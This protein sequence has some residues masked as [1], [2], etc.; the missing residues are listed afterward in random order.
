MASA[1]HVYRNGTIL[2]MDSGG[3]Q[4]QAL[5]VRGETILAVGSDAEIMALADPHTVVTD[6][7]GRTM[8]PGFID[9]HSHFV[10]AG[11]MAATQLD[12][13]SPPVGGVKNIAEIK[14]LIRAKAAE[15]PKGEW[16]L[17]FGYDDTGLED[18]R[19]PLASDIDEV[20]PEHPVLLRHVSGHLSACN[21][22]ALAKA[23][24]TKDTP[25]PVGG[26]IRRD[27][28]G[29]PNGVLEEPPAREPV[30][31]HIPA[32]T[33]ADW[34][35]GI[36]A[37]CAAYTAKGVTTAQ[38]GFTATGDWGAL[39][40]AHELGL[41]R[42]RVQILPGLGCCDLNQFT[43]H[44]SGT[45][46]TA[47]RKISL[48]AVKHLVDGSLQCY[49]GCLSNPYHK[50]IYDLPDGPMWRGY[51]QENPEGFI[52]RIVALH[53]QGW[54]IAIH[55]NGD[56]AIQ[57]ILDAYE[58]AQKRY[59]RAD[60]RH[61]IIHCQTVREDQ[62][63]RIKRL[64][65]VPSFFVVHT[66]FW[67]DRHRDIFLGPDR[68]KRISPLRSA[69]KRGILFSNH[70]DTFVTPI[71]PLLSVWSAVNRITSSGQ[72]LGEEYTIS[73]MDALRSV[74]SWAAYQACEETSKGSL[75]PGKLAD[76]VV[77]GDNPLAVD[78]KAIRDIPVLA[79]I[80]GNELVYGSLE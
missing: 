51:I 12:L 27:E 42:N 20:A 66:Y 43:S 57:L 36:K 61:I 65:V 13:S 6:L 4:A 2:T 40:R 78:K 55:G 69:L 3:S 8:L 31:R 11:L 77:L 32:P 39:K 23:N 52:D 22:L 60:A 25:D 35:E 33:E 38:D 73:V 58:E 14:G 21:G 30:F 76:M 74:T 50:I 64:G 45:P 59:P 75:E 44:A 28:H 67:G 5:A 56:E 70:N 7:R 17:G 37:A 72:V 29:N 46:L 63:D 49:T 80:V 19:H 18:K 54:Q 1:T 41:L 26:V 62:L 48:G 10:S 53:Q 15:T 68:A 24:Y 16:I 34:M 9:G 47:D 71:D 79:T